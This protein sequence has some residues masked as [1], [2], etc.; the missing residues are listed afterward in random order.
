MTYSGSHG[1][2]LLRI[3]E[4]NMAPWTEVNG[5]KTYI[6]AAGRLNPNFGSI[7]HR[8]S[9]SNSFYNSLQIG[10]LKSFS[11]GLRAQ[12]SY[13]FSRSIDESSGVNSQDYV[14]GSVY[15][16][17]FYDR[18]AD[19]GLSNFWAKHVWTGN[20]SYELPFGKSLTGAAAFLAKGW[21]IN[22]I[23]TA[24]TG[25]PFSVRM[26]FN[27]SGN[28]NTVAY[29]MNERPNVNPAFTGSPI[30][31]TPDR[32]W[33]INAFTLPQANQKGNLGR[34]T[35]I[36]PGLFNLDASMQKSFALT[37]SKRVEFRG[38]FFNTLNHPNFGA[39]SGF[40]AFTGI[41]ANG[42][43]AIAANWGVITST[44]T[45]SRQVQLALKLTF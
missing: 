17:D 26:G 3:G 11:R 15:V 1:I 44:V 13:T 18:K 16:I 21:Q 12:F 10:A 6:P 9:D 33:D 24:Q 27:R 8:I 31:G 43:P 29:A 5:I 45:S 40:N 41:T 42:S 30:L 14:N 19:R 36:G 32:Y 2:H 34:N 28:L 39:P 23:A 20:A 25:H 4:A 22:S 37:E 7:T 38:E 35:L